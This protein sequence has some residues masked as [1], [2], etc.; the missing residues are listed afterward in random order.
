MNNKKIV[1]VNNLEELLLTLK[2]NKAIYISVPNSA[3]F[4]MGLLYIEKML[5]IASKDF[6]KVYQYFQHM[7]WLVCEISPG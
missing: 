5:E 2:A 4:Y 6:P 1:I 7:Q 3:V